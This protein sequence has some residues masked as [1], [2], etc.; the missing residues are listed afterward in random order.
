MGQDFWVLQYENLRDPLDIKFPRD[1]TGFDHATQI[2][3]K[4]QNLKI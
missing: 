1:P 3:P 4:D 2:D